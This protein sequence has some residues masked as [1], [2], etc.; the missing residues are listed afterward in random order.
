VGI[1]QC[2]QIQVTHPCLKKL[3][4]PPN[5]VPTGCGARASHE[6]T[7]ASFDPSPCPSPPVARTLLRTSFEQGIPIHINV[8]RTPFPGR[9]FTTTLKINHKGH[10]ERL[11]QKSIYQSL[12][13]LSTLLIFVVNHLSGEV[14]SRPADETSALPG[15]PS[16]V[17][18]ISTFSFPH[19]EEGEY[20]GSRG[21][22][23]H[24]EKIQSSSL[25]ASAPPRE[26]KSVGAVV[27]AGTGKAGAS[28]L[29]A[30]LLLL[31]L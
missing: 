3:I 25:R 5:P 4:G 24:A 30:R 10:K 7:N 21:A 2:G 28:G 19:Y 16:P 22:A 18:R 9:N 13:L 31:L 15:P 12:P 8:F 1:C 27:V 11:P 17:F 6:Q 29:R 26:K 14:A 23:E 20:S